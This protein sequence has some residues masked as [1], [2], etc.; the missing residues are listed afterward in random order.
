VLDHIEAIFRSYEAGQMSRRDALAALFAMTLPVALPAETAPRIG[1]ATGLNHATLYVRNVTR[2]QEFYQDLFGMPVLTRQGSGVN[3]RAGTSFI[4]LYPAGDRG[5]PGI[6]HICLSIKH[7]DARSALSKLRSLNLD[8]EIIN[9][10]DTEE[11]YFDDPDGISVQ[12]QD[13]SYRGGV[14]RLGNRDPA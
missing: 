1:A 5:T 10:G 11:L 8:A 2:S 13:T 4:G 6:D 3:L 9:R 7:F 12:I 14:G